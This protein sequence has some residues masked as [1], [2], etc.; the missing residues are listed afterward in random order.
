[1]SNNEK[2]KKS[3][4]KIVILIVEDDEILLRALYILFHENNY[5]IATATDGDTAIKM[6]QRIK[7]NVILLDLLLPKINGF[8]VLKSL[9]SDSNLK[10]IPIIVLSN[11]G[12]SADIERAKSLGASD[13]FV[14]SNTNLEALAEKVKKSI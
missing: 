9:K 8:D 4:N 11:L 10:H 3:Q 5:T 12:D 1:M 2:D 6:A 7:P 14:K 13:Y